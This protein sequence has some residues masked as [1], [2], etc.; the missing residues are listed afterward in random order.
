[1]ML[2]EILSSYSER[3]DCHRLRKGGGKSQP[4]GFQAG[5]AATTG[6]VAGT[7][8]GAA[9]G[10]AETG[11]ASGMAAGAAIIGAATGT[12]TG[13]II[14]GGANGFM[15]GMG[16]PIPMLNPPPPP[17]PWWWWCTSVTDPPAAGAAAVPAWAAVGVAAVAVESRG[18]L[19]LNPPPRRPPLRPAGA[20]FDLQCT[21]H[22]QKF[23]ACAL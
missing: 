3:K 22:G 9:R 18:T 17:P 14:G 21:V 12:A 20:S 1:M 11:T 23:I 15:M 8:T 10:G 7:S 2:K 5:A 4:K 6:T 13:I 19:F 16:I